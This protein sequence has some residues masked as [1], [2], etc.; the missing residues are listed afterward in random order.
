MMSPQ[1]TTE[2]NLVTTEEHLEMLPALT[3]TEL[4]AHIP[5]RYPFLLVDRVTA[6][7][8]G[9]YIEGYKN[10][11]A[12][13]AFF[14]GHFPHL[15]VMPGVLQVEALAQL[16]GIMVNHMPEGKGKIGLFAGLDNV[17]FRRMVTPGDRLDLRVELV[18]FRR[19][20]VKVKAVASVN[21]ETSVEADMMFSLLPKSSE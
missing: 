14:E 7:A 12:N 1:A 20:L 10:L 15:P 3:V 16:G 18:Q 19:V 21:G 17:R 5:H 9:T 13:E 6:H 11:T 8:K 2:K 4:K